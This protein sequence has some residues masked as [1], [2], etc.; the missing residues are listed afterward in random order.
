MGTAASPVRAFRWYV[1]FAVAALV[2]HLILPASALAASY[3]LI[4]ASTIVPLTIL[5]RGSVRGTR[6]PWWLLLAAM[7]ALT[8]GSAVTAVFGIAYHELGDLIV[9]VGHGLLLASALV[10]VVRRGRNDIGGLIDAAVALMGLGSVVW[11]LLLEPRLQ[12]ARA[13]LALQATLLVSIFVLAGVL[14]A[15]SR[16]WSVAEQPGV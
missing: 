3:T 7:A 1:A 2:T 4:S 12:A 14:G 9:T 8:C 6:L 10:L 16:V 11:T 15:L 13:P 5:L